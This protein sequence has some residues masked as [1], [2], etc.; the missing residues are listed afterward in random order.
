MKKYAKKNK[1][2]ALESESSLL[3]DV[4]NEIISTLK[5]ELTVIR[6]RLDFVKNENDKLVNKFLDSQKDI[7]RLEIAN[8]YLQAQLN[9]CDQ[10]QRRNCIRIF[11]IPEYKNETFDDLKEELRL[12]L[13]KD[14]RLN[15]AWWDVED[16]YRVGG[17]LNNPK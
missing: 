10:K 8:R 16:I 9:E 1:Q 5:E 12:L 4:K 14:L 3:L 13:I 11:G 17:I 2:S 7:E 15:V 6:D